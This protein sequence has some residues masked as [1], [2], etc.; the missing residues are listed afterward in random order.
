MESRDD[1]VRQVKLDLVKSQKGIR[2]AAQFGDAAAAAEDYVK[3]KAAQKEAHT[4]Y[5]F[6]YG[7]YSP[8]RAAL[9]SAVTQD[10][11]GS[12]DS[13]LALLLRK[14]SVEG[15][16]NAILDVERKYQLIWQWAK[17]CDSMRDVWEEDNSG[18][19]PED[20]NHSFDSFDWSQESDMVPAHSM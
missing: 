3:F 11:W 13:P 10:L 12:K 15:L 4:D 7:R 19:L 8:L 18:E 14:L 2:D 5:K 9:V 6:K 16:G 20:A 17:N 1:A